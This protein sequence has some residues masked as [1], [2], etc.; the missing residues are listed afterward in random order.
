MKLTAEG[1]YIAE[2]AKIIGDVKIA[3]NSSVW[4]NAVLRGDAN[5]IVIGENTNIQDNAVLHES[6]RNALVI[7][8]NVTI[9]HGAVVH[10]CTIQDNVLI[11]MG[12]IVLDGAVI[13]KNCMIGAGALVTQ[14]KVI[15]EGYLALGN[16][17][18]VVR[19]LTEEEKASILSN[20]MQYIEEADA[21]VSGEKA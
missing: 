12:A 7:G 13:E 16:P 8:N 10:G 1:V 3:K 14:N 5:K 19:A 9:G 15:P 11:G 6:H 18:K 17:A 21:L 4:Y 20:A 2:G